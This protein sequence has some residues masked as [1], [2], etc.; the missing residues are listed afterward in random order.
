MKRITATYIIETAHDVHKAA[1]VLAGEQSSGTFVKVPGETPELTEKYRAKIEHLELLG[2]TKTPFLQDSKL[3]KNADNQI[4]N[5]AKIVVSWNYDNVGANIA[6]LMSTIAGN[7]FELSQFSGLKLLDIS[8]PDNFKHKYKGPKFAIDGTRK[9]TKVYDRPVIGTIIKPSVGL[10]PEHTALQVKQLIEAGI[11][12]IKD[13][14]LMGDPPHSPFEKRVSAVMDVINNHADKTGKKAMYAFNLS[15]EI[16]DM[17]RRHDFVLNQK[18]TCIM[19]NL[20]WVGM[21]AVK[22]M[23]DYT[24]LPVHGHRN[25]WGMYY[26]P[27]LMGITFPVYKK[28]FSLLGVDHIHTNGLRNK[29][30]ENDESVLRSIRSCQSDEGGTYKVMPVLS[31]GQWAGQAADTFKLVGNTD[32]MYLCGGGITAHPMGINAGVQS[33]LIAWQEAQNGKT[34]ADISAKYPEI[35]SALQ[36]YGN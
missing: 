19:I 25:G 2:T 34:L 22:E 21:S 20:N 7:L 1:E 6:N 30:C 27:S 12:F 5:Q 35:N 24:V 16:D 8:L 14:E 15:G 32:L 10:S 23:C 18:G 13:D 33:I 11:D 36:F 17:K 9:L 3:P 28:I 31:S 26:R 29:F 4:F